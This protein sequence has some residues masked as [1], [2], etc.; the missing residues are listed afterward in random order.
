MKTSARQMVEWIR[1]SIKSLA[2]NPEY[3]TNEAV[4]CELAAL[5]GL[6]KSMIMKLYSGEA[7]NP[8]VDAVDRL[9]DAVK[10]ATIKAAA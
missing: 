6:S 7:R 10:Q 2:L 9:V 3:G 1:A 4:Y 5:S 8:T